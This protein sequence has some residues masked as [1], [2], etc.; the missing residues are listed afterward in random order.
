[1]GRYL[2]EELEGAFET[3]KATADKAA[4]TG[5]WKL[6]AALF[7]EDARYIEHAYGEFHG[8]A[9]IE[10]WIVKVMAPFPTMTFPHNWSVIDEANDAVIFEVENVL[11]P[12]NRPDGTPYAFPNWTRIVYGGGGKWASEEDVYNPTKD[13]GPVLK[14]WIEAGGKFKSEEQVEM[15]HR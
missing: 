4:E 7:T 10:E 1:M 5:D 11:P 6:W 14:A 12:P 9:A 3:F 13:G 8:R 15:V 2:R